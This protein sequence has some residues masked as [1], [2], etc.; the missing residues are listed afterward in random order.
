MEYWYV[1]FAGFCRAAVLMPIEHP[2]DYIKTQIQA[3]K[4]YGSA[5]AFTINHIQCHGYMKLYSGLIPNT[6]RASIKQAYRLPLMIAIPRGYRKVFKSENIVQ[7]ITG[8]T[9]ALIESYIIC[10]LERI[11]VW[12]MTA[13][14]SSLREF[15]KELKSSKELLTGINALLIRQTLSWVSFL[16]FTSVFKQ[17]ALKNKSNLDHTDLL[18]IGILVGIMNTGIIMPADF[19]KTHQQKFEK[20]EAGKIELGKII[21]AYKK[22]TKSQETALGKLKIIYCGWKVR[23]LNYVINSIFTVNLVDYLENQIIKKRK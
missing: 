14:N 21:K 1:C 4:Y 19:I 3:Q 7:T 11:K 16:G 10:P 12:L 23:L 2:L 20:I 15:F 18:G 6:V 17:I 5:I 13:P 22:L 8:L 9:I